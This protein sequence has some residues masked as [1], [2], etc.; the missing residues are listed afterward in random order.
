M[1]KVL[2]LPLFILLYLIGSSSIQANHIFGGQVTYYHVSGTTYHVVKTMY[3]TCATSDINGQIEAFPNNG[4]NSVA[5]IAPKT[6]IGTVDNTYIYNPC[7][8]PPPSLCLQKEIFETNMNLPNGT[9]GWMIVTAHG[10]RSG[11]L[12]N[13]DTPSAKNFIISCTVPDPTNPNVLTPNSSPTFADPPPNLCLND[14][15]KYDHSGND[16]DGDALNYYQ[17]TPKGLTEAA[18]L[19]NPPI[20]PPPH[21]NVLWSAGYSAAYPI[22]ANPGFTIDANT[23]ALSGQPTSNGIY[24]WSVCYEE[25]RG[26]VVIAE[27]SRDYSFRVINCGPR[28]P[29]I[30]PVAQ[31]G[32][33]DSSG[34]CAS[35][36]VV[37]FENN[38]VDA[39]TYFW[40]FGDPDTLGDTSTL[41]EPVYEYLKDGTYTVWLYLNR[42]YAC[43]DSVPLTFEIY[44]EIDAF[45]AAPAAQCLTDNSFEFVAKGII[46]EGSTIEWTFQD[47]L[48]STGNTDTVR[49]VVFQS[50]GFKTIT[51]R[52]TNGPCE[53]TFSEVVQVLG[54]PDP[55]FDTPQDTCLDVNN[56]TFEAK[57]TYGPGTSFTWDFGTPGDVNK[58]TA[59]S[60]AVSN[61]IYQ[62]TGWK[63]VSLT[64][65]E[66]GCVFSY[67]DSMYITEPPTA[68]FDDLSAPQCLNLNS[69]LFYPN[70][71]VDS[72][73]T[74]TWDFGFSANPLTSEE[75]TVT[76]TYST[77]GT[78]FPTLTVYNHGCAVVYQDQ[79]EVV[80]APFGFVADKSAM[81]IDINTYN[82]QG[83]GVFGGTSTFQWTF[84]NATP[85]TSTSQNV[86]NV[87]FN[88]I[89]L[90]TVLF[91]VTE[92]SCTDIFPIDIEI[93]AAPTP[94]FPTLAD[95]CI[96]NGPFDF[97]YNGGAGIAA[98][99]TWDLD[100]G[101]ITSSS[102]ANDSNI[103]GVNFPTPGTKT[104]SVT[105]E[106]NG[107]T[108]SYSQTFTLSPAPIASFES[109]I[110]QCVNGNSF[111]FL[112]TSSYG[113]GATI[114]WD[115][116]AG[117][118]S[119]TSDV[120]PARVTFG[121]PGNYPVSLSVTEFGCIDIYTDTIYVTE[122]PQPNF[123]P[124]PTQ[125][126]DSNRFD[127]INIGTYGSKATFT[128][129]FGPNANPGTSILENPSGVS[130]NAVGNQ[131][132]SITV[133]E[134]GC[135]NTFAA[136]VTISAAPDPLFANP[137]NGCV[138]NNNY[139]FTAGGTFGGDANFNWTFEGGSPVNSNVVNP[140]S[141]SFGTIGYHDITL[142]IN[143]NG[144]T[145][146]Y[147]DSVLITA[148]PTSIIDPVA[149]QC[150]DI[151]S[152]DFTANSSSF[153][154]EATFLWDFGPN[155]G[156]NSTDLAPPTVNFTA[157]GTQTVK[158]TI[159]E[160][161]CD[162][163]DSIQFNVT[164]V[165]QV[166]FTYTGGQQ[167]CIASHAVNF[168]S[169]GTYGPNA[170]LTWSF[171][172]NTDRATDTNP[173]VFGV[174]FNTIG[175]QYITL[176]IEENGCTE[177]Y[178]DS[179]EITPSPTPA[180]VAPAAQCITDNSF[181]FFAGGTYGSNATV[182]WSFTDGAPASSAL[183]NPTGIVF[184]SEGTK[185]VQFTVSEY[186][187]VVDYNFTVD[188]TP[189][190]DATFTVNNSAQCVN[191]NSFNFI[192]TNGSNFS[193]AA[194]FTWGFGANSTP[195]S[196]TLKNPTG[197]T[198][199]D[200]G[201]YSVDLTISENGCIHNYTLQVTVYPEP[202]P[203]FTSDTTGCSPFLV[204]FN[205]A[206]Y[207]WIPL[208]YAWDFGD[209]NFGTGANPTHTYNTSGAYSV[210]L[211]VTDNVGCPG[212]YS[213]VKTDQIE[214][215]FSPV[216][217]FD[218]NPREVSIFDGWIAFFNTGDSI[219]ILNT[220][221]DFDDGS[222]PSNRVDTSHKYLNPGYYYPIL[223]QE[224]ING[225][226][227][228]FDLEIY[229]RPE[230]K[231]YA[232]NAFTPDNDNI[233]DS[234]TQKCIGLSTYKLHI[235]NRWG[236]EVYY[237][238]N[239]ILGWDGTDLRTGIPAKQDTYIYLTEIVDVFGE[240]HRYKGQVSLI[241]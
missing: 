142:S 159:S 197:I 85:S 174:Q 149:D 99:Y 37:S 112:N 211:S 185:N 226:K 203:D 229:I 228:T 66:N 133:T 239:I 224:N 30:N 214:V 137:S 173:N 164:A 184:N 62:T 4:T 60:P 93:T 140:F 176:S 143:E 156:P 152:Y 120:N 34:Y 115:F 2:Q 6:F 181:D 213:I 219:D 1:I 126:V 217:E 82:F 77:P 89:G 111:N 237:T 102:T 69:Y 196:S 122:I 121:S 26:G 129:D 117:S 52:V 72:N 215:Y 76:V 136:N 101:V 49:D 222:T 92:N 29:S 139:F 195:T 145:Y 5:K 50:E 88:T 21:P 14:F 45:F 216:A 51:L 168:S 210:T 241:K 202:I 144:C 192:I 80:D 124:G 162:I 223:I 172:P 12:V 15:I 154:S 103:I 91:E 123:N 71:P 183:E 17:C 212:T 73:S 110:P 28:N 43:S 147:T 68:G 127:F 105:V 97:I 84:P 194:Q 109:N 205:D 75:D 208:T 134:Y 178:I 155:E 130:F 119:T 157:I 33:A 56:Y 86:N 161:G 187:C 236:E 209:G 63:Y 87:V 18:G 221:F 48:P 108:E 90:H 98:N 146:T 116:G 191:N 47:A 96:S 9:G 35:N 39:V 94:S 148:T 199:N 177:A 3:T 163:I 95:Q 64:A 58:P 170:N 165:P 19:I 158:F 198:Y 189:T 27:G 169:T 190:P 118:P 41:K 230:F 53:S 79:I 31:T 188:V 8:Q 171:G 70:V 141:V 179:V 22:D 240:A 46:P 36:R 204:N 20:T 107:C 206:S 83:T 32:L 54:S 24:V 81:C 67:T 234:Y 200:S 61:V 38:S 125:C 25:I 180:V 227:D 55:I 182:F 160:N 150:I 13:I 42:G 231:F 11:A 167:Q 193:S 10:N 138:S 238:E 207:A 40:D 232:P 104:V 106:E 74:V 23:G 131:L 7:L 16:P 225:C 166:S 175:W 235:Y 132:V 65:S 78:Y 151:N 201:T 153:G 128:W 59:N 218:A 100:D 233:N 113:A 114:L 44:S 135:S 57:G 186:G 220:Y